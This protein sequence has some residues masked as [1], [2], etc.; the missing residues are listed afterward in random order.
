MSKELDRDTP[1]TDCPLHLPS[2]PLPTVDGPHP[3]T[4]GGVDPSR[5]TRRQLRRVRGLAEA[6]GVTPPPLRSH[7]AAGEWIRTQEARHRAEAMRRRDE[8]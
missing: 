3:A 6:N 5:L 1:R 8:L 7:A 4:H 2:A